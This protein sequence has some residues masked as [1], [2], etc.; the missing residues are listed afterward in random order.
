ML[1]LMKH[2]LIIKRGNMSKTVISEPIREFFKWCDNHPGF[3][4]AELYAAYPNESESSLRT[5]KSKWE[6]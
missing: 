3:K 4:N 5:R 6:K 1:V 2:N